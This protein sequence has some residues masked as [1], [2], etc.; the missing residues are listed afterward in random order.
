MLP[1]S[2]CLHISHS[3]IFSLFGCHLLAVPAFLAPDD[4]AV[5]VLVVVFV[6]CPD[7]VLVPFINF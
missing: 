1:L 7:L 4:V 3:T 2:F 6:A 5:A